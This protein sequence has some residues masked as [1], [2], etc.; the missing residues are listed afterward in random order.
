MPVI[1]WQP[2][3]GLRV[4]R[5]ANHPVPQPEPKRHLNLELRQWLDRPAPQVHSPVQW[6]CYAGTARALNRTITKRP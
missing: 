2:G 1:A 3:L 6:D 5:Q 4:G